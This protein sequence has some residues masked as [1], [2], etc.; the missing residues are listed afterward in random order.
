[1]ACVFENVVN[2]SY[3]VLDEE[4]QLILVSSHTMKYMEEAIEKILC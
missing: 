1:M 3:L 4:R 2:Q